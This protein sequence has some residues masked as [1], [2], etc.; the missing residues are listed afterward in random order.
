MLKDCTPAI[1]CC[2][3]AGLCHAVTSRWRENVRILLFDDLFG[4]EAPLKTSVT[5]P[6]SVSSAN[7][8]QQE[9]DSPATIIYTSGTSGEAKGVILTMRNIG[10]I[11]ERTSA[12]LEELMKPVQFT[13]DHRVFHYLPFCFAASWITLLTCLFRNNNM[14]LSTDLS[15]LVDEIKL[16]APHYFVNV[17]A[18]LEKIRSVVQAQI[19]QR[20][21]LGQLLFTRGQTAWQRQRLRQT[22]VADSLWLSLARRLVFSKIQQK[23]GSNLRALICGSAPLSEET[24]LFFMMLGIPVLQVYGLTRLLLYVPWTM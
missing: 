24:Q 5:E 3:D 6:A 20:G 15:Q 7:P 23:I 18:V 22:R 10:F 17:P 11:L 21:G 13:G 4:T 8:V 14:M 9:D 12:R 16:A 19:R 2:S 1:L